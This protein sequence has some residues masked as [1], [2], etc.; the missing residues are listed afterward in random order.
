MKDVEDVQDVNGVTGVTDV[1]RAKDVNDVKAINKRSASSTRHDDVL[2]L[3]S[4]QPRRCFGFS[5][6]VETNRYSDCNGRFHT[7]GRRELHSGPLHVRWC[8]TNSYQDMTMRSDVSH[9]MLSTS[10]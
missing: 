8:A 4:Y 9:V 7:E 3:Y 10:R 5:H 1:K 2:V 6:L